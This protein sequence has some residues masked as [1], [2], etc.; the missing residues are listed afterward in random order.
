MLLSWSIDWGII[1]YANFYDYYKSSHISLS[2]NAGHNTDIEISLFKK[3]LRI[4][5]IQHIEENF[6]I[7]ISN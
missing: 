2:K 7:L 1:N 5:I 4:L 3:G 6:N